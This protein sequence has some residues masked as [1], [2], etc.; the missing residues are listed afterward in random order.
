M[1]LTFYATTDFLSKGA[2]KLTGNL[3]F[4]A[5]I[6]TNLAKYSSEKDEELMIQRKNSSILP[7]KTSKLIILSSRIKEASQKGLKST[8]LSNK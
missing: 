5:L 7:T 8:I 4:L 2:T 1:K 6:G 3:M